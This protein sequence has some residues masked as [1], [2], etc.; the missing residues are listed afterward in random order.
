VNANHGL[1]KRGSGLRSLC[2][3]QGR[4]V[5]VEEVF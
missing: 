2:R 1:E 4:G 5:K 3:D